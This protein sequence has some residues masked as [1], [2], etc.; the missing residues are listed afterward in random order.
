MPCDIVSHDAATYQLSASPTLFL[1]G[2]AS[3]FW[4]LR[5]LRNFSLGLVHAVYMWS[6]L[7]KVG[8]S[9]INYP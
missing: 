5:N 7:D 6:L 4:R 3:V 2:H 8:S 1:F 9:G